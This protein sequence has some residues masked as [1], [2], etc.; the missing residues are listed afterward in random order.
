MA[1]PRR[2]PLRPP[3]HYIPSAGFLQKNRAYSSCQAYLI[4]IR[5]RRA[6]RGGG[7]SSGQETR[8]HRQASSRC[9]D[10]Q[11]QRRSPVAGRNVGDVARHRADGAENPPGLRDGPRFGPAFGLRFVP[12]TA[13]FAARRSSR[14]CTKAAPKENSGERLGMKALPWDSLVA[15]PPTVTN[16]IDCRR[17]TIRFS[18]FVILVDRP[19]RSAATLDLVGTAVHYGHDLTSHSHFPS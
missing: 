9:Q 7:R 12:S 3:V 17:A 11:Q 19:A 18:F 13:N 8:A 5:R 15:H 14:G 10:R 6:C 1:P 4:T 2:P 16:R